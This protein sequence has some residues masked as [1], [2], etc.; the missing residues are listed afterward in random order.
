MP[1]EIEIKFR[2]AD[3][4]ELVRKLRKAGFRLVTRGTHE[5][6]TLY[7]LPGQLLRKRKELLRLR[8]YKS[9]WKLTHKVGAEWG[10]TA[11]ARNW[12]LGWMTVQ[13]W[14]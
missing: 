3:V 12:R 8:K 14:I 11:A 10:D 13:R 2:C 7:D 1:R 4:R 9:E 5:M 6:N